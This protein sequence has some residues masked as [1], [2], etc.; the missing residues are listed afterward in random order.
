MTYNFSCAVQCVFLPCTKSH[1][2][3]LFENDPLYSWTPWASL[4]ISEDLK[5]HKI[6]CSVF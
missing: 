4:G 2:Q 6:Q 3:L 5:E 1:P